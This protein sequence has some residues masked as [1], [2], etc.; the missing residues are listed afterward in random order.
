[1]SE[2]DSYTYL[3]CSGNGRCDVV[4]Q[5]FFDTSSCLQAESEGFVALTGSGLF[6]TWGPDTS[7]QQI[8]AGGYCTTETH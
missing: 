1:M 2:N 7:H 8:E 5:R 3:A 6:S 4:D